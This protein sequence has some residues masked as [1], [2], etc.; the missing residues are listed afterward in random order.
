MGKPSENDD[1][2]KKHADLLGFTSDSWGWMGG[3]RNPPILLGLPMAVAWA[4]LGKG[5]S[6]K[7]AMATGG[8]LIMFP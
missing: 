6:S 5:G 7:N 1:F 8:D 2:T 4:A 3:Y